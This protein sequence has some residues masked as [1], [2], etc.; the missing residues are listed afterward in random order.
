[1]IGLVKLDGVINY[2]LVCYKVCLI[3]LGHFPEKYVLA[4]LSIFDF[5][6]D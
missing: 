1:M 2:A 6:T 5:S 3:L 4:N